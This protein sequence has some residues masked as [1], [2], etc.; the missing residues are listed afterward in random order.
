MDE[1]K[2]VIHTVRIDDNGIILITNRNIYGPYEL[3]L[4]LCQIYDKLYLHCVRNEPQKE[5]FNYEDP[6]GAWDL[7]SDFMEKT[8]F[9]KQVTLKEFEEYRSRYGISLEYKKGETD[10]EPIYSAPPE[11]AAGIMIFVPQLVQYR[12]YDKAAVD[13]ATFFPDV[14]TYTSCRTMIDFVFSLVHYYIFNG[15]KITSCAHCGKLFATKNLKNKY[16]SKRN[17]TFHGYEKYTCKEAV[18]KISDTLEKRRISEYERLRQRADEYGCKSKYYDTFNDF[19][20]KCND[21]KRKVKK[22]ASI[23]LLEEYK[24]FLYDSDNLRRKYERIKNW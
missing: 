11:K 24:S 8:D 5:F 10:L 6:N 18:K 12:K 15:Y 14:F 19:C 2:E 21:F 22:G 3:T 4:F 9:L 13:A 20:E 23:S 1:E 16:C 17:S 7:L